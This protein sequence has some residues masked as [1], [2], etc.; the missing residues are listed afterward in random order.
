MSQESSLIMKKITLIIID[1]ILNLIKE[2]VSE[3]AKNEEKRN[4]GDNPA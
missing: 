1:A 3:K 2:I 4:P